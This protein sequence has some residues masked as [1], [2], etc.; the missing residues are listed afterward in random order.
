MTMDY[1]GAI[2]D[3]LIMWHYNKQKSSS[4]ISSSCLICKSRYVGFMNRNES[5]IKTKCKKKFVL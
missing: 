1:L 3:T 4:S 2:Y 5:K